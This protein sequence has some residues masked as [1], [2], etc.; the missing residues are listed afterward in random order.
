[1]SRQKDNFMFWPSNWLGGTAAMTTAERGVYIDLLCCQWSEGP[2][3]EAQALAAGRAETEIVRQVLAKKFHQNPDG[4]WQNNRLEQERQRARRDKPK[5]APK[6]NS[7][8][9]TLIPL[10]DTGTGLITRQA[11][12]L[13]V[14]PCIGQPDR[15]ELTAESLAVWQQAFP[16]LDILGQCRRALAWV[17]SNHRKTHRGMKSFLNSWLMKANDSRQ[18]HNQT[19]A[20][21]ERGN[22]NR[23]VEKLRKEISW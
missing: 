7:N 8:Q 3:T 23:L 5:K 4:T 10:S 12:S 14:F 13:L 20:E 16:G 11:A 21:Q 22:Q 6:I 9:R 17:E 2:L 18:P 1:M 19:F 15:W